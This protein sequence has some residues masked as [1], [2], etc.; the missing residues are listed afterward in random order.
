MKANQISLEAQSFIFNTN[1]RKEGQHYTFLM[2]L[3]RVLPTTRSQAMFFVKNNLQL[4]VLNI[5]DVQ[6]VEAI[7]NEFG[8]EGEYK[9]TKN[10]RWVRLVNFEDLHKA[11]RIKYNF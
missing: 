1:E 5:V 2:K 7:L 10:N 8:F 3:G 4:S 9:Y 11:L 6:R